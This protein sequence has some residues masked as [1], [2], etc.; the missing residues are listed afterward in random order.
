MRSAVSSFA[1]PSCRDSA[2]QCPVCQSFR[3]K[4]A[5]SKAQW[6]RRDP[7]FDYLNGCRLCRASLDQPLADMS[8][9]DVLVDK[10]K[11]SFPSARKL[12]VLSHF[13]EHHWL[14]LPSDYRKRLSHLGAVT[15]SD[16]VHPRHWRMPRGVCFDAGPMEIERVYESISIETSGLRCCRAAACFYFLH[17]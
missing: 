6:Q 12:S 16:G 5:W 11:K 13:V 4:S 3:A 10:Y 15:T 7:F 9:K 17:M 8:V 2:M 14:S 1:S